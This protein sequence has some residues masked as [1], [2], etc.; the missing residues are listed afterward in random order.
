[1][2]ELKTIEVKDLGRKAN[3]D[4]YN[5]E[6]YPEAG[7]LYV[8]SDGISSWLGWRGDDGCIQAIVLPQDVAIY[9]AVEHRSGVGDLLREIAGGVSHLSRDIEALKQH[10]D[11]LYANLRD[12][13]GSGVS[14]DVLLK[15]A[16]IAQNP[17]LIK[18]L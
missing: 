1:M 7:Q 16:A 15:L 2:N 3:N 9:Y 14:E 11:T 12:G 6:T 18:D 10:A 5:I 8:L 17:E 13:K 4:I